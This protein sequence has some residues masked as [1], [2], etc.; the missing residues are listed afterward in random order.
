MQ[1]QN[2][3]KEDNIV[4]IKNADARM[5][6]IIEITVKISATLNFKLWLL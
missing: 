5:L 4:A 3:G 2:I 6:N 1:K